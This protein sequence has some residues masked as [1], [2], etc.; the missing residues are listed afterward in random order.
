MCTGECTHHGVCGYITVEEWVENELG[1]D[2]IDDPDDGAEATELAQGGYVETVLRE[3][4]ELTHVECVE[5]GV[6]SWHGGW[7]EPKVRRVV[8]SSWLEHQVLSG[9]LSVIVLSGASM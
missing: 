4:N 8:S 2:W 3:V 9:L 5:C 7:K 1:F 6:G